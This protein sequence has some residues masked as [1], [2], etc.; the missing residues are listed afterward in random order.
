MRDLNPI[1]PEIH[2]ALVAHHKILKSGDLTKLK[3]M[4]Q[5]EVA[6]VFTV[7]RKTV[8]RWCEDG[9]WPSDG[10][11]I[12]PGRHRRYFEAY[13]HAALFKGGVTDKAERDALIAKARANVREHIRPEERN[14]RRR[15]A[16]IAVNGGLA[17]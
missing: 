11:F 5:G 6:Y 7:D 14:M 3:V 15:R 13:V 1:D 12:T 4:T 17:A 8:R 16:Q 9:K 2:K 10:F